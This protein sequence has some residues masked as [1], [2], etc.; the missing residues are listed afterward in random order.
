MTG[1]TI[2][3]SGRLVVRA[4]KV[5]VDTQLAHMAK[6]VEDAQ[7][8]KAPVQRLADKISG[9]FVPIVITIA[10]AVFV[11]WWLATG[12]VARGFATAVAVL[13]VACPCAL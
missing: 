2:N 7:S 12:D 10:V 1:A 6:L 5:G 4:E 3:T 8:G 13:I 9:V 11:G